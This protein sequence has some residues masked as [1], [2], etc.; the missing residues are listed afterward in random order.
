MNV[1]V[2]HGSARKGGDTDTLAERFLEGLGA[3]QTN[4]V[5]HFRP[6]EMEIAHCRG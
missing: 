5:T 4:A 1:M 3:A 6:I 2:L